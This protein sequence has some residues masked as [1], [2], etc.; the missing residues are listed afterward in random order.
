MAKKYVWLKLKDDFFQQKPIKKL[1][2]M[3]SG[4]AV[5]TLIYLK[6]QLLSLKDEGRLYFEGVEEN[7]IDEIALEIDETPEDVQMTVMYLQK[8]QLLEFGEIPDEYILPE[9]I[10]S[11][12]KES[13]SAE[14][15]RKHREKQ[16]V[17]QS[18][19]GETSCNNKTIIGNK[20]E[21]EEIF[22]DNENLEKIRVSSGL[23]QCNT[24]VTNSNTEREKEREK[25]KEEEREKEKFFISLS[26]IEHTDKLKKLMEIIMESTNTNKHQLSLV[27]KPS[28]Y[29]KNIDEILWQIHSSEYLQGKVKR[30]PN[31]NTF[32]TS[33]QIN[34]IIAG[35]YK[36]TKKTKTSAG[37]NDLQHENEND[38]ILDLLD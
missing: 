7:F 6:M 37:I 1:R 28:L 13:A 21:T 27:F 10:G 31:L 4:G 32:T 25:E 15:V 19:S 5:Y 35:A 36:T 24:K 30:K 3:T 17:L 23:L 29:Q 38:E 22:I 26:Q 9:V 12:G 18:N 16:K 33:E 2:K 20:N 11:I 34:R 14:R 8:N